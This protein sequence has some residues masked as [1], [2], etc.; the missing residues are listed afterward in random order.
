MPKVNAEVLEWARQTAGLSLEEAAKAVF[1]DSRTKSA[2][3]KLAELESGQKAPTRPQ[4]L[5]MSKKYQRPLLV[6]YLNKPPKQGDRGEDFRT[7]PDAPSP[8]EDPTLDAVIRDIRVRQ[9]LV[10]SLLKDEDAPMLDF[11][12]SATIEDKKDTLA[13]R[14]I[15]KLSF[16]RNTFFNQNSV[17]DAFDYLRQKIEGIGIF[18]LLIGNLGSHHTNIPVEAFRGFTIADSI[19]PF[20][21]IND[22]DAKT[23]WSFT[24]LHEVVH[25]WLGKT[26]ISDPHSENQIERFCNDVA[27]EILLPEQDIACLDNIHSLSFDD[28]VAEITEFAEYRKLSRAMIA[29]KLR[30][31][32]KIE[33]N[34][35]RK[36]ADYF[37]QEWSEFQ[38]QVKEKHSK[39]QGGPNYYVVK[40]HRLGSSLLNLVKRALGEG[41]ISY[42]KASKVL[43]VKPKGVDQ[44]LERDVV[45]GSK[46]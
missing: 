26:G 20:I 11:I 24:A 35:W 18:T 30:R 9:S 42:T 8:E 28:A 6:F 4:L 19:A 15:T 41:S 27:G 10:K 39:Q 1:G 2:S 40:R 22:R 29:Y 21:V 3:E 37:Q 23:A 16:E 17:K 13:E 7:L 34:L 44:L 45:P 5:K 33:D 14:I 38:N 12:G 32:E 46:S 36:M 25:L 31:T 43:G